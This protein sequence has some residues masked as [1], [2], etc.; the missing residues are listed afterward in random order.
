MISINNTSNLPSIQELFPTS[1]RTGQAVDS[2]GVAPTN[3][4][5]NKN[6]AL[7]NGRAT[8]AKAKQ[9][10]PEIKQTKAKIEG[11][12]SPV[13]QANTG[14]FTSLTNFQ[15]AQSE[16]IQGFQA[17][18][19]GAT[20]PK[21]EFKLDSSVPAFNLEAA[22]E[23]LKAGAFDFTNTLQASS[24]DATGSAND[25]NSAGNEALSALGKASELLG[26][27]LGSIGSGG[28]Q[29][30][31]GIGMLSTSGFTFGLSSI[32]AIAIIAK[33]GMEVTQGFM[34]TTQGQNESVKAETKGD[35]SYQKAQRTA[36][37]LGETGAN[38]EQLKSFYT[39]INPVFGTLQTAQAQNDQLLSLGSQLGANVETPASPS[40]PAGAFNG[41]AP[42]TPNTGFTATP[43]AFNVAD[44]S[45]ATATSP[46]TIGDTAQAGGSPAP[47]A[48]GVQPT[49][50]GGNN[51][52]E[53]PQAGGLT[54]AE[55]AFM[56]DF[57]ENPVN[58]NSANDLLLSTLSSKAPTGFNTEGL[59]SQTVTDASKSQPLQE[60]YARLEAKK[61]QAEGQ[62]N[63]Q[64]QGLGTA[65]IGNGVNP[66]DP[67]AV[68]QAPQDPN[69]L[70][71]TAQGPAGTPTAQGQP[72]PQAP[73][74]VATTP[75]GADASWGPSAPPTA[76]GLT[77]PQLA[78]APTA[79]LGSFA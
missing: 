5:N 54:D 60:L 38:L 34:E 26:G 33:G 49:L 20:T 7:R 39:G 66:Q 27:G 55:V 2:S 45:W 40:N 22:Q 30:A 32:P 74:S 72:A 14:N 42:T 29:I 37:T 25:A 76:N 48:L 64:P 71:A 31:T 67:N 4:N 59:A 79:T 19:G 6:Q 13:T 44:K 46:P 17:S 41:V 9:S 61:K 18:L 51:A 8:L 24:N 43:P 1:T 35:G 70:V 78:P 15:L 62:Q 63:R 47:T 36:Q 58:V 28:V 12:Q 50:A 21:A 73:T 57:K 68:A 3:N 10:T 75:L 16:A 69:G 53:P 23:T 56:K 77:I 65:F 52:P 11:L